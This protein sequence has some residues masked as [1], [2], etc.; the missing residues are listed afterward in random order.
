MNQEDEKIYQ[1]V[2]EQ[3]T[4]ATKSDAV[5]SGYSEKLAGNAAG[6]SDAWGYASRVGG[7][8][9]DALLGAAAE[10]F[11]AEDGYD[12]IMSALRDGYEMTADYAAGVQTIANR[13]AGIG[14]RGVKPDFMT[15]RAS[16]I[17][18]AASNA[19]DLETA[20]MYLG[21]PTQLFTENVVGDALKANEEFQYNA[22]LNPMI[23]RTAAA[24]CCEWCSDVAGD[25]S[26]PADDEI[27]R[28]HAN[29]EC[30]VEYFPGNGLRQNSHT[31]RWSRIEN[32]AGMEADLREKLVEAL[33]SRR[34]GRR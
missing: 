32:P 7:N 2:R 34:A 22:G 20:E 11:R 27:Y 13:E 8:V 31:K 33:R 19:V 28:R 23:R 3:F 30:L 5:L 1:K 21:W 24:G 26:Y 29:C 10:I 17:A 16:G 9:S 15:G 25:Y 12:V 6:Y 14:I 4:A 18:H